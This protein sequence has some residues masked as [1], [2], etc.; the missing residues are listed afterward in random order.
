MIPSTLLRQTI[1]V[2]PL[3]GEGAAGPIF[4]DAVE[5]PCRLIPRR[6]WVHLPDATEERLAEA[7]V[8]MR[9][10]ASVTE[11]DRATCE[12]TVYR[13]LKAHPSKLLVQASHLTVYLGRDQ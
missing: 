11:G 10:D 6:S 7:L 5:Y 1:S 12:G 2:E 8:Y 3:S 9:P 4:G 13:V